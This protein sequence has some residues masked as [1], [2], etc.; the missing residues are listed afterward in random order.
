VDA[1]QPALLKKIEDSHALVARRPEFVSEDPVVP[2]HEALVAALAGRLDIQ[3]NFFGSQWAPAVIDMSKVLAFQKHIFLDERI[4]YAD[5]FDSDPMALAE[6]TLP[7]ATDFEV[8]PMPDPDGMGMTLTGRNRNLQVIGVGVQPA[9]VGPTP[10]LQLPVTIVT[11]LVRPFADMVSVAHFR[12][13]YFLRDGYHRVAALLRRGITHVPCVV[14]EARSL[15]EVGVR[16]GFFGEDVIFGERP[17]QLVDFWNDDVAA[18]GR[19]V[20]GRVA[21]HVRGNQVSV[22]A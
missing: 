1:D 3:A 6:L 20:R 13:R 18:L 9:R 17:P 19:A 4:S 21:A 15:Q 5:G 7:H 11:V 2:G 10:A 14:M 16:G 22:A 12:G 8:D